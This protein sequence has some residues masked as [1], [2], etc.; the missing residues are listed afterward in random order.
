M[1]IHFIA[2]FPHD[3]FELKLQ[4]NMDLLFENKIN[5]Q[6]DRR[7]KFVE[8]NKRQI[9]KTSTGHPAVVVCML[10]ERTERWLLKPIL[11][12]ILKFGY[13]DPEDT[14]IQHPLKQAILNDCFKSINYMT[15][16]DAINENDKELECSLVPLEF[17]KQSGE[18]ESFYGALLNKIWYIG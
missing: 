10:D 7:V 3:L 17:N 5:Q 9:M 14:G 18:N 8:K 13:Y 16:K 2:N 6:K 15:F 1:I 4:F 11:S 12:K